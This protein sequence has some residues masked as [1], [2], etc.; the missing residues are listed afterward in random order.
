MTSV[1]DN[2]QA[3][4]AAEHPKKVITTRNKRLQILKITMIV[5]VTALSVVLTIIDVVH[6][7]QHLKEKHVLKQNIARGIKVSS[8][9][10]NLQTERS[11]TFMFLVFK[12]WNTTTKVL[13]LNEARKSTDESIQYFKEWH[14]TL[15]GVN[16]KTISNSDSFLNEVRYIRSKTDCSNRQTVHDL[17]Q[18]FSRWIHKLIS[19][20]SL[21]TVTKD[22]Q[23]HTDDLFAYHMIVNSKEDLELEKTFG[24]TYFIHGRNFTFQNITA[25]NEKRVRAQAFLDT[26]LQ[27]SSVM[28]NNYF[29]LMKEMNASL[30]LQDI[31]LK[32][33][34]ITSNGIKNSSMKD[35]MDWLDLMAKY[36]NLM[37]RLE[38]N[39]AN[40]I[41]SN[42][43]EVME[44]I[45]RWLIIRSL[46]V[47]FAVIAVPF[48]ILSLI[49]VQNDFYSYAYSLHQRV[50]LEQSRTDFL[51]RENARHVEG[52][53]SRWKQFSQNPQNMQGHRSDLSSLQPQVQS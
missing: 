28:K 31:K 17:I 49:R 16:G 47:C 12:E 36:G 22:S 34:Y 7:A 37:L 15:S 18:I 40:R 20:I 45:I 32:R 52:L 3:T 43:E 4:P 23:N 35:A 27:F 6:T 10:H 50:G 26:A 5:F 19:W 48:L 1:P 9:I 33:E 14:Y 30:W 8:L 41:E 13:K 53:A 25:Y 39:D 42:V 44:S 38:M 11:Q 2:Y 21:Y 29:S 51:M 46:L 24:A